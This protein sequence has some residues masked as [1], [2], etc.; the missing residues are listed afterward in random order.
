MT[1]PCFL[2]ALALCLSV[3][4]AAQAPT[5]FVHARI[6]T[7][8]DA[9][10]IEDGTIL[11][12]DGRI[13]AVGAGV[14]VPPGA[15]VVDVAGGTVMPG[16]VHAWSE[17]GLG[18]NRGAPAPASQGGRRGGGRATPGGSSGGG[19]AQVAAARKIADQ[20]YDRQDIFGDLLR[21][22]VT[23]LVVHPD[24]TG[25]PGQAAELAPNV[26]PDV[27]LTLRDEAYVVVSPAPGPRAGKAI[28]EALD[29]AQKALE[30]RKKPKEEPKTEEKPAEGAKP[31]E[32]KPEGEAKPAEGEKKE[33]PAPEGKE[34]EKPKTE[35][36][37]AEAPKPPEKKPEPP[38]DPNIEVLADMLDGKRRAFLKLSS[39]MDVQH[40]RSFVGEDG[41]KSAAVV[42]ER[43]DPRTG[44]LSLE[45]EW[46]KKAAPIVLTPPAMTQ[47]PNTRTLVH[48]VKDLADA[49]LEIGFLIPDNPNAVRAMRFDVM[50]LVRCGMPADA[51]LRALTAVPAKALGLEGQVGSI[52][53]GRR[54]DFLVFTGDPL[55][56]VSDLRSVYLAGHEVESHNPR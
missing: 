36:K 38:K 55:D 45:A 31:A 52:A 27:A 51:A 49:G 3:P 10:T 28:K 22:G 48:P 47:L 42:A 14:K 44:L 40:Y 8:T 35:E 53:T 39:A 26:G 29:K 5:A 4:L 24:G 7:M 2:T 1:K 54:A 56:P 20:I 9:G 18:G 19:N 16:L 12:R 13:E 11:V 32:A 30:E 37:P 15:R 17:A 34:G 23:T 50:E 21:A 46:L 6:L 25:F 41:L 43:L 33:G